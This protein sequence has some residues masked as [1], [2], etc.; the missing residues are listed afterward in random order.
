MTEVAYL[1]AQVLDNIIEH[2]Y[3]THPRKAF[4]WKEFDSFLLKTYEL[5]CTRQGEA[6]YVI[7]DQKKYS[8]F[9]LR[10]G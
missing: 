5:E 7:H 10:F 1:S 9:L 3:G 2:L 6:V 4:T 8:E